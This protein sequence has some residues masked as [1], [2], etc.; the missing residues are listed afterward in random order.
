M[1]CTGLAADLEPWGQ[2]FLILCC[3]EMAAEELT[4]YVVP[5]CVYRLKNNSRPKIAQDSLSRVEL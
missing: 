3:L 2:G 4:R 5:A 1:G